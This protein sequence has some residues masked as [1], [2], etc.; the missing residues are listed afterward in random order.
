M[1]K[2]S[3]EK[4]FVLLA[5]LL[6]LLTVKACIKSHIHIIQVWFC[7]TYLF[8]WPG[9]LYWEKE[10]MQWNKGV[11]L[12]TDEWHQPCQLPHLFLSEMQYLGA[13]ER[14]MWISPTEELDITVVFTQTAPSPPHAHSHHAPVAYRIA[15]PS[16]QLFW[17]IIPAKY[18]P[19]LARMMEHYLCF[20]YRLVLH[21][22]ASYHS[23][24]M[25]SK[26]EEFFQSS[27]QSSVLDA[28]SFLLTFSQPSPSW[29]ANYLIFTTNYYFYL[30]KGTF[31]PCGMFFALTCFIPMC[32]PLLYF[33]G[34]DTLGARKCRCNKAAQCPAT[35][36]LFK[37][38]PNYH[39]FGSVTSLLHSLTGWQVFFPETTF[40][41]LL[42]PHR[43]QNVMVLRS[44]EDYAMFIK[45]PLD[46]YYFVF[47]TVL[48]NLLLL[49]VSTTSHSLENEHACLQTSKSTFAPHSKG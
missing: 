48:K 24:A 20:D 26:Q 23:C 14:K 37:A 44:F 28:F 8:T 35:P 17:R 46:K 2:L 11:Y 18:F 40:Q 10:A 32:L 47:Y 45:R 15:F 16:S 19:A 49:L 30:L 6:G 21:G 42:R 5:I 36:L 43:D 4:V 3:S 27:P 33:T 9:F 22:V 13:S 34:T 41:C 1:K 39:W 29:Q 25:G 12:E 31:L 7:L 38:T